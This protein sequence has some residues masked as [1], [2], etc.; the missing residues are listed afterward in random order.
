MLIKRMLS[1]FLSV[2]MLS[3]AFFPAAAENAASPAYTLAGFDDTAMRQWETNHFFIQMQ[4]WTGISFAFQQYTDEKA[5]KEAKASW[6]RQSDLPDALFKASLTPAECIELIQREVLI[7]LK[8]YL[9]DYAPNL[10]SILE[11]RPEVLE[12]I[13]L[14]DGSIAAL[15]YISVVP[16]Q[17]YI[18]VNQQW[19]DNLR[20]SVPT[21]WEEFTQV[22]EAF[23][24]R[25]PNRNGKSDEIPLGFLGPFDLKFLAH[26]F[27]LISNDFNIFSDNGTVKF[28]PLEENYRLFVTWCRDLYT[29]GLLDQNGFSTV[30]SFRRVTDSNAA[31]TY[32]AILTTAPSSLFRVSWSDQYTVMAPLVYDGA[33]IY[34]DFFGPVQRGT[35]A[36]TSACEH[37]EEM[38]RWV[39]TLYTEKGAILA[40]SG[41]ENIDYFVDGDGSW[42]LTEDAQNNSSMFVAVSLMDG[43]ATMPG[44]PAED[45][46]MRF[47]GQS[48]QSKA[49]YAKQ[50]EIYAFC[51]M[52]FPYTYLTADQEKEISALQSEIGAYVDLQLARWVLGEEEIS[53]ASFEAFA[54][55]LNELGLPAFLAFWQDI[56]DNR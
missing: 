36:V 13:T 5:W 23:K 14:P 21:T 3:A 4:E 55:T 7:D 54:S 24:T 51:R 29:A 52:P 42:R 47:S 12:A 39:D 15:P 48:E 2:L 50:K 26:A 19:L 9:K 18:W 44:M 27:G 33:Q 38:L 31:P 25:D 17:N 45:F 40:S 32:G 41:R 37:P 46:L 20:L 1:L 56:L 11:G 6:T 8:P 53:D 16:V 10:W 49:N 30:D 35:F 34:R 28:M 43:G 22:L